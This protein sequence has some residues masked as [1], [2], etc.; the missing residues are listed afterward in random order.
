MA[1]PVGPLRATQRV[2]KHSE[3]QRIQADARRVR[4]PGFVFLLFSRGT[5]GPA[6][7]GIIATKKL[8]GAVVRNRQKRL[9]REAFR[10][11]RTLWADGIDVVVIATVPSTGKLDAVVAEWLAFRPRIERA[12]REAREAA[13][14]RRSALAK[15]GDVPQTRP[16]R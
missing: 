4:A 13:A 12:T 1:R 3:F 10:A 5:D 7:L 2:R 11:T 8:G 6:R 15:S 9:I 16:G 14:K